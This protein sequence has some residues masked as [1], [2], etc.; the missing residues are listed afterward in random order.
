MGELTSLANLLGASRFMPHSM[1]LTNEP[2]IV[3]LFVTTH[4]LVGLAY[5]AIAAVL[6]CDRAAATRAMFDNRLAFAAFIILC[7]GSHFGA[8]LTFYSAVYLLEA[9]LMVATCVVS[10]TV[11]WVTVRTLTLKPAA[12]A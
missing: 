6:F 11:A 8:A 9:G 10:L 2:W 4:V 12:S 1:C 7:G 5:T 3:G